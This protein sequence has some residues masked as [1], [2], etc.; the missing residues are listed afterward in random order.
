MK[1][2]DRNMEIY[3]K[4]CVDYIAET[5]ENYHQEGVERFLKY[6]HKTEKILELGS[7][8]GNNLT[9]MY[10]QGRAIQGSDNVLGFYEWIG[11]RFACPFA[12]IDFS[13]VEFVNDYMK[14]REIIHL[15]CN[16]ALHHLSYPQLQEFMDKIKF[17]G[18][19]FFSLY[20]GIGDKID[21]Q[22]LYATYYK[23]RQIVRMLNKRFE[24]LE[25]WLCEDVHKSEKKMLNYVVKI[26]RE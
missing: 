26:K 20:E 14:D 25:Q 19:F 9:Y 18:V 12:Y 24:I 22:G 8:S 2:R 17:S 23:H 16:L 11:S 4:I 5:F 3:D 21:E 15:F 13:D 1:N 6:V 7:G 10:G